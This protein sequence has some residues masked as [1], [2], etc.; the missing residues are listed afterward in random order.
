[1]DK[2]RLLVTTLVAALLASVAV[3]AAAPGSPTV[4][5]D[6]GP[7]RGLAIDDMQ[8]FR[9]IPYAAPPIGDLRWRPPQ[10]PA[11][12]SGVR[13]GT[14]FANHCPQAASPYGIASLTEDCLYLNVFTPPKTNEGLP[15]LLPVMVW[16]HGGGFSVR[17]TGTTRAVSW[18][19]VSSS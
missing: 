17:A 13:D 5:T 2:P 15:H 4:A 14:R 7:I 12:W 3:S 8:V 19:K 1:M 11:P 6:K 16:I 9:G 10:E 18:P